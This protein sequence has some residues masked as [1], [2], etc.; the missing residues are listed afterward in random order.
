MFTCH[1]TDAG[2]KR[3]TKSRGKGKQINGE[4]VLLGREKGLD[5]EV[6]MG[7]SELCQSAIAS[8]I[9]KQGERTE[10]HRCVGSKERR[11]GIP[12]DEGEV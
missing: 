6:Q 1:G 2:R 12:P 10:S 5:F 4:I 9:W 7:R 11:E 3:E 8:M